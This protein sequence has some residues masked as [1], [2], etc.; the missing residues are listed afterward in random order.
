MP[1]A[2]PSTP[3]LSTI[4]DKTDRWFARAAAALLGQLPCRP[5]CSHCCIGPFPITVLDVGLLQEGLA[6]LPPN[7]RERIERRAQE[8]VMAME[9][10]FPRLAGSRFLDD[11]PDRDVD[12][13]ADRFRQSPCPALG[14]GGLC[15]LYEFRP[16]TCRSMGIPTEQA[17]S[18]TGAC[19][20]QTFVPILRLS[21]ALRAEEQELARQ[22]ALALARHQRAEN[23][24][25]E[26]VLL[27]YGFLPRAQAVDGSDSGWTGYKTLC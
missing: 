17:G 3:L 1:S 16:L 13:L 26:E 25:G 23:S 4:F 15:G 7:E 10:A 11:W 9:A 8:Q 21:A 12:R 24:A 2:P 6:Q 18:T 20:I 22:E 14:E 5:G 27:P 19:E